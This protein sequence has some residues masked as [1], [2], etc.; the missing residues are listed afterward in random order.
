M[1]VRGGG[2][3]AMIALVRGEIR[4]NG[5]ERRGLAV[6]IALGLHVGARAI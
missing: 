2:W 1:P 6:R 4:V 5:G 3:S